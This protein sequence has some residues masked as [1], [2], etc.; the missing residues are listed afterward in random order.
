MYK[1]E[2]ISIHSGII[3]VKCKSCGICFSKRHRFEIHKMSHK[4]ECLVQNYKLYKPF[5]TRIVKIF[6]NVCHQCEFL[7][8]YS[9]SKTWQILYHNES[10]AMVFFKCAYFE[11]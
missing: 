1:I 3:P 10:I 6:H 7:N 4:K 9:S 5:M 2:H 11:C 8:G